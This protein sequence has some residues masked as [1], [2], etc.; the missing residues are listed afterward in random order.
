MDLLQAKH[1]LDNETTASPI[2]FLGRLA[3]KASRSKYGYL[4]FKVHRGAKW[5]QSAGRLYCTF[6]IRWMI[7][8]LGLFFTA[9]RWRRCG[10]AGSPR[11]LFPCK[12]ESL[13]WRCGSRDYVQVR[14]TQ[15]VLKPQ[16]IQLDKSHGH[17]SLHSLPKHLFKGNQE[18]M[19]WISAILVLVFSNS[20]FLLIVEGSSF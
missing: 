7:W 10:N 14:Q 19:K 2:E 4:C 17:Y 1:I 15:T 12:H 8:C 5:G 9:D 13:V 3:K 11:Q 18:W 20:I 16:H 6:T